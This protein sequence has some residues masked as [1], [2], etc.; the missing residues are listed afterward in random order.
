MERLVSIAS[1][2]L[3]TVARSVLAFEGGGWHETPE[4]ELAQRLQ[5]LE[6][7]TA[8]LRAELQALLGEKQRPVALEATQVVTRVPTSN[9]EPGGMEIMYQEDLSEQVRQLVWTKGDYKIVPY[10]SLWG[11]AAYDTQRTFPG[12]YV[13]YVP[14]VDDE[15]E[16]AFA[17]DTRR[18]RLGLDIIGPRIPHFQCAKSRGRV[19]IDFHGAFVVENKP[20][21]LLRHAYAEIY[22]DNFRLLA[23]QYWD[24]ISP[25]YPSTVSYSVGWGGGNIGYRRTQVRYERYLRLSDYLL[26]TP[27]LSINQNI[28]SDFNA[29]SGVDPE[30]TN[31]PILQSRLGF[32]L[33]P[34]GEGCDPVT[35]G[36]SGHIGEQG[37]DFHL[38]PVA[39]DLRVSTW[40][41]NAD[42]RIPI[43]DRFGFQGE[44]FTGANLSAF[45]GG[46]I[47]GVDLDRREAV[48][49]MGGWLDVWYDWSSCLHSHVGYSLDDPRNSDLTRGRTYNQSYFVNWTYDVTDMLNL[50]F[51]ITSWKTNWVNLRPGDSVRFRVSGRYNF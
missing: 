16:D 38:P 23:G 51:E 30:A 45:L 50:G 3:C 32:T 11:S 27:A 26:V 14:S 13:L 5:R 6:A 34:R 46:V 37:F 1:V 33:G 8:A 17:I 20:G 10:G 21:V 25:L 49:S 40:S 36:V 4:D 43:T 31:W 22:D 29:E 28:V 39:D 42:F 41:F 19:E 15:G 9:I 24:L 47:Q 2:W 44:F 48:H 12:V 18:T 7:E 35:C